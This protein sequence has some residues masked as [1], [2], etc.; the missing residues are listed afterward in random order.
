MRRAP[1]IIADLALERPSC[2]F[3][4]G[5][6]QASGLTVRFLAPAGTPIH[7]LE[8]RDS[9]AFYSNMGEYERIIELLLEDPSAE[10]GDLA[11]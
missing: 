1:L 8:G 9:V 10:G 3:E 2:Y 5:L 4:V 7:Q 11:T 6:A